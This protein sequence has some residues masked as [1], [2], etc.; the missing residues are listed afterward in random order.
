MDS[1]TCILKAEYIR[2]KDCYEAAF[3]NMFPKRKIEH[4][5][6]EDIIRLVDAKQHPLTPKIN[7]TDS[8]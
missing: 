3:L 4:Y 7:D 1:K 5:S 2:I 6:Y 8:D